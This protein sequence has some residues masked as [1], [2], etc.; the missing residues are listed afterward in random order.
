MA[1]MSYRAMRLNP[2]FDDRAKPAAT[3]HTRPARPAGAAL[4]ICGRTLMAL[5]VLLITPLFA[6][7]QAYPSK[8]IR[9]VV[10]ASPGGSLDLLGRPIAQYLSES[11]GQPVV[12]DNR[13]GASQAIGAQIVA[14]AAP[15]GYT[16]EVWFSS[17]LLLPFSRKDVPFDT[18]RDFTPIIA[19]ARV[20]NTVVVNP[21]LPVRSIKELVEYAKANPG[22][23]GYV[24][25]G[26]NSSQHLGGLL[27]AMTANIDILHIPYKGGGP[28]LNDLLGGQVQ[29]GILVM[30]TVRPHIQAGKLR[31][32]AV[33][34]STRAKAMPNLPT[35][36][37]DIPGYA[38]PTLWCG[39]VGPRGLPSA[40]VSRLNAE[41]A[42]TLVTPQVA[43]R[44]EAL[45]YE[46]T[47]SS[48]E[49]FAEIMKSTTEAY[50]RITSAAG[51]KPQ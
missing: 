26:A 49:Q 51:I 39:I 17:Q 3:G 40:I 6:F 7:A 15:D 42:R 32:L 11:L 16:L 46:V 41:I 25:S 48:P 45:G 38:M 14:N 13:P 31:A 19:T 43:K 8:A 5:L 47:G 2:V 44:L 21:S 22:K 33:V 12:V 20:P 18:L 36:G 10:P 30:G 28:A 29:A 24:T 23:I 1:I 27:L 37:E 35:V 50:R 4:A 34:E 9:L